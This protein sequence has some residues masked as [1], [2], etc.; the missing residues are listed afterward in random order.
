M[1]KRQNGHKKGM[2]MAT[3]RSTIDLRVFGSYIEHINP[4]NNYSVR[5]CKR[6]SIHYQTIN[7]S[8]NKYIN[9]NF[10]H[11]KLMFSIID[12][13]LKLIDN[14]IHKFNPFLQIAIQIKENKQAIKQKIIDIKKNER[15]KF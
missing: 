8:K 13:F 10:S 5:Y 14:K 6:T 3:G 7:L 11:V 2:C 12:F 1:E 4:K 15:V 9:N